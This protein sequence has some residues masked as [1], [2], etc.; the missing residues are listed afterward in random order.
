M[1]QRRTTGDIVKSRGFSLTELMVVLAII[2]VLAAL[3]APGFSTFIANQ[4]IKNGAQ[5][6]Q[7][8]FLRARSEALGRNT[9]VTVSA[10]SGDWGLGWG[11]LHP[12]VTS[13][14]LDRHELLAGVT[15][16][17]AVTSV[18]F[19]N[20]GRLASSSSFEFSSP[21]NTT[22]ARCLT[23]DLFGRSKVKSCGCAS[24]C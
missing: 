17:S 10:N 9:T 6:L 18:A 22:T 5:D 24:T 7:V 1:V 8:T 2:A 23:V 12:T 13:E 14:Y 21:D 20:L 4:R 15:V 16:S 19:N 3:A 11:T